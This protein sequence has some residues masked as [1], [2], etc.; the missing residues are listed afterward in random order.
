MNFISYYGILKEYIDLG[1]ATP[2]TLAE[3][4]VANPYLEKGKIAIVDIPEEKC[5]QLKIG[6][7]KNFNDTPFL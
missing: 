1:K 5:F 4:I 7:G 6:D 2:K 3:W